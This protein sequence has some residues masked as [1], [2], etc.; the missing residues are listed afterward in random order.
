MNTLVRLLGHSLWDEC[1]KPVIFFF[2]G[3]IGFYLGMY[4]KYFTCIFVEI[5]TLSDCCWSLVNVCLI[6]FC[7]I[8]LKWWFPTALRIGMHSFGYARQTE[9]VLECSTLVRKGV[10][11]PV[12]FVSASGRHQGPRHLELCSWGLF[13][14]LLFHFMNFKMF[15]LV[16]Y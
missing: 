2:L 10:L 4:E 6:L 3:K 14:F 13:L 11:L 15:W 9:N 8:S 5:W 7:L 12:T 1:L 16:K